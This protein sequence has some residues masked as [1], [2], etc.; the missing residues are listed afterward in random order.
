MSLYKIPL[1]SFSKRADVDK[2]GS[3]FI[4][5]DFTKLFIFKNL[6]RNEDKVLK[7]KHGAINNIQNND[8]DTPAESPE[9]LKSDNNFNLNIKN[10]E[11]V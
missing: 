10:L 6:Y 2:E 8:I 4:E 7:S 5:D 1:E 11:K 3:L 9:K